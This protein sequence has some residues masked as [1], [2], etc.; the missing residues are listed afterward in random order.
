MFVIQ[1]GPGVY[2]VTTSQGMEAV[3]CGPFSPP[4]NT[5]DIAYVLLLHLVDASVLTTQRWFLK[6]FVTLGTVPK[7]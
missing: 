4:C 2:P 3:I 6:H 1:D 7:S 5:R